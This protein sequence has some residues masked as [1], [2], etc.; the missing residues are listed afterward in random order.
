MQPRRT[1]NGLRTTEI[2]LQLIEHLV[3]TDGATLGEVAAETDFAKSTIHNH[4]QTLA[5]YG[6]VI[7]ENNRYRIGL[8]FYHL[9]DYARKQNAVYDI[10]KRM[11]TELADETELETDF[12]V[13]ENG[14]TVSLYDV[15]NYSDTP[16]FLVDGRLFHMH[17]TASGK[18]ILAEYPEPRVDE[19]LDQ[20]GLPAETDRTI[21]DRDE[22]LADLER[23]RERGYAL[24][25]EE[26]IEGL[27]AVSKV[28]KDPIGRVCGSLNVCGPTY[29]HTDERE[30]TIV[31]S[32]EEKV[33]EFE[34]RIAEQSP[35]GS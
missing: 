20:W 32:L 4:L 35:E 24:N 23:V 19:I 25:D 30:R 9:G 15:T 14:R 12:T 27:W 2:S 1:E 21:T 5:Q 22:L 17:S 10:A 11:V 33:A 26:A 8:K 6:Y 16:S 29:I 3:E 18:A 13:E 28:V 7:R 34:R 31:T